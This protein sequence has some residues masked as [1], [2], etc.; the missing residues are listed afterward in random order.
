M[1]KKILLSLSGIA[2]ISATGAVAISCSSSDQ[3]SNPQENEKPSGETKPT[4]ISYTYD[5]TKWENAKNLDE[6][7]TAES[8]ANW[9]NSNKDNKDLIAL[10]SASETDLFTIKSVTNDKGILT[11]EFS[12]KDG[13]T[14]SNETTIK[15]DDGVPNFGESSTDNIN[16]TN[17]T[18]QRN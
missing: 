3:S 11:F 6:S 8:F 14:I 10:F 4:T 12:S 15:I 7:K 9:A 1:T 2:V 16:Y 13:F 17:F 5:Q 18:S